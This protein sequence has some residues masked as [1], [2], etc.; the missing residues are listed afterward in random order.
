MKEYL[1][2]AIDYKINIGNNQSITSGLAAVK[3]GNSNLNGMTIN[4]KKI[5]IIWR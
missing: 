3:K 1:N 4:N 5:L 2:D